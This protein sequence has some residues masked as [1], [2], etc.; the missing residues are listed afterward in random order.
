[1][2]DPWH[3]WSV[4]ASCDE[5]AVA[6]GVMFRC[7]GDVRKRYVVFVDGVPLLDAQF[8]RT[9]A[10]LCGDEFLQIANGVIR[11]ALNPNLLS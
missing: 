5:V 7:C 2:A 4:F 10:G 3:L 11:V 6:E 1:M 8:F 9:R